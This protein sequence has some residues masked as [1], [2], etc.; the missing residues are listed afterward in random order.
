MVAD[1]VDFYFDAMCPWAYRA[2]RWI[3]DVR[4]QTG[5]TV[6]WRFFSLEEIN[7]EAGKR[8]PWE[9]D[10][11]YG[12]SQLRIAALLRRDGQDLVDRW[13]EAAGSAFF[14]RGEPTFS[15]AGAE[16]VVA[17][18]G[19]P[20]SVVADALEDPTTA[21]EVKAD[22][23]H[24]VSRFGGH[25]VPTLVFDEV[26]AFF[27]PVVLTPPEGDA[28]VRLWELVLGWRQFPDLY[29]LRRPK[30]GSDLERIGTSFA[31]YLGARRWRTIENPAP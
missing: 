11:S 14:D 13:Y 16:E 2:S 3:R 10:W 25:G 26:D 29:E 21:E 1:A 20:A 24:L 19:L 6:N 17:S 12:W 9:R 15:P 8:H 30:T 7:R 31:T 18:L 27:G 4:R 23:D 28:A 5:I 22:H